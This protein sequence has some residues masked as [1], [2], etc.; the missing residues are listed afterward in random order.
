[1]TG[2]GRRGRRARL[3]TALVLGIV[4]ATAFA[5]GNEHREAVASARAG[6]AADALPRLVALLERAPHD[7]GLRADTIVVASWAGDDV[8]AVEAMHGFSTNRVDVLEAAARSARNLRRYDDATAWFDAALAREPAR[9]GALAGAAMTRIDAGDVAG[10]NTRVDAWPATLAERADLSLAAAY[11]RRRSQRTID[12]LA[13]YQRALALEPASIEAR[14]GV[15]VCL[16]ELGAA[17]AAQDIPGASDDEAQRLATDAAA[18]A[19][20]W[21]PYPPEDPRDP[22]AEARAALATADANLARLPA[23]NVEQH[24]RAAFDRMV[25]LRTLE[26]MTEVIDAA[27]ALER[28]GAALPTYAQ[29]ALADAWLYLRQPRRAIALYQA[30]LAAQP[31]NA[32]VELSLTYAQL[33]AEDFD[34]ARKTLAETIAHNPAWLRA[35]GLPQ[36]QSNPDRAR[37]DV[38]RALVASFGDDL[39]GAQAQLEALLA[40]AP[41]RT[42]LHRELAVVYLRRGW[43]RRALTEFR[44]AAS[45]D[46][47]DLSLRLAELGARRALGR[48]DDIEAPLAALEAEAPT[49]LH[50]QRTRADW[51]AERG[52]QL[53]L[54]DRRGQGD[55]AVFG[56]RDRD[57]EAT[58][59]TPL[60][61]GRWRVFAQARR[62]SADI[63]EGEVAY[64]RAGVG[65][66]Y[67]HSDWDARVAWLPAND[68]YASRDAVETSVRWRSTDALWFAAESN[69]ATPD[70]PLRG[71]WYGITAR[72]FTLA[73][74]WQRS[75]LDDLT[76]R[77]TRLDFSDGNDRDAASANWRHRLYTTPHFKLDGHVEIGASRNTRVGAPY[78]N[79]ASDAIVLGGLKADWLTWRRYEYAFVQRFAIDAGSYRQEGYGASGVLRARYEHEWQ[80]GPG[81]GISY[82]IAWYRQSYDGRRESRRELFAALHLGGLPW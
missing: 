53:D 33:E 64:R 79:P 55:S 63:P 8:R 28:D 18:Q 51:D 65:V 58:L 72:A 41:A 13:L 37:A 36:P 12:A 1:M 5:G 57:T 61:A 21:A 49:N 50:V 11:V 54:S 35:D 24:R 46:D 32:E 59:A 69:T 4:S 6:H 78:F 30:A 31:R 60:I 74:G 71:R 43:P 27:Q 68:R 70:A 38:T 14:D 42:E 48:Y 17:R 80:L 22:L 2:G 34:A 29:I 77:L 20:R 45:L 76:W 16:A 82:G 75:E 9:V 25:A 73:G 7:A 67:A 19:I 39:A 26:R 81:V 10:A 62:Q 15:R 23:S 3:R 47:D 56:N 44:I 66:R 52:W 40:E